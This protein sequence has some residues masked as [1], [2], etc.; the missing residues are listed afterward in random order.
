VEVAAALALSM[1]NRDGPFG[2]DTVITPRTDE[3]RIT[4]ISTATVL[5]SSL[6]L[7]CG[8]SNNNVP[9][10]LGGKAGS[11]EAVTPVDVI[12]VFGLQS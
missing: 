5:P 6:S 12:L 10:A 11:Y 4:A 8:A 3:H 1:E 7:S 2:F 9:G